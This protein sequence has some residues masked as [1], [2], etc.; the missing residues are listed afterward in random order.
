[1]SSLSSTLR[2]FASLTLAMVA[3][4]STACG[5]GDDDDGPVDAGPERD[6]NTIAECDPSDGTITGDCEHFACMY[7]N[8]S[9]T[10]CPGAT[11][12][13]FGCNGVADFPEEYQTAIRPYFTQCSESLDQVVDTEVET[14]DGPVTIPACDILKC[15]S[16][17]TSMRLYMGGPNILADCAP[18]PAPA[19]TFRDPPAP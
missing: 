19:C 13:F 14:T 12:L 16:K 1:M 7:R 3:L 15:V 17:S 18:V 8:A 10:L 6:L 4:S 5:G 9:L 11:T 2:F